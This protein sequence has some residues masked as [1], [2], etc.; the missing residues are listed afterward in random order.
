LNI[1]QIDLA[2]LPSAASETHPWG[3]LCAMYKK[4]A[5]MFEVNGDLDSAAE[6]FWRAADLADRRDFTINNQ[7]VALKLHS[8][9]SRKEILAA[10]S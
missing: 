1:D 5:I 8:Y 7:L 4:L 2:L 9:A 3:L 6:S 10:I